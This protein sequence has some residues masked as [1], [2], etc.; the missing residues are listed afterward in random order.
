MKENIVESAIVPYNPSTSALINKEQ[1]N[2][3]APKGGVNKIGLAGYDPADFIVNNQI[4]S[5]KNKAVGEADVNNIPSNIVFSVDGIKT[6]NIMFYN[7]AYGVTLIEND[8]P[9]VETLIGILIPFVTKQVDGNFTQTEYFLTNRD[10]FV[11]DLT[12]EN[13][14]VTN[15]GDFRAGHPTVVDAITESE[16]GLKVSFTDGSSS[17]VNVASNVDLGPDLTAIDKYMLAG[18]VYSFPLT[19]FDISS[20]YATIEA[21]QYIGGTYIKLL[22][23]MFSFVITQTEVIITNNSG[24]AGDF[25]FL[26]IKSSGERGVKPTFVMISPLNF[27]DGKV[28]IKSMLS[29]DTHNIIIYKIENGKSFDITS[30]KFI[31]NNTVYVSYVPFNGVA[32]FQPYNPEK[33]DTYTKAVI[34]AKDAATLSSAKSY[35]D[36]LSVILA[37]KDLNNVDNAAFTQKGLMNDF[38]QDDMATVD[39]VKLSEKVLEGSIGMALRNLAEAVSVNKIQADLAVYTLRE[40][41]TSY[42]FM[43]NN[44]VEAFSIP[45]QVPYEGIK[46]IRSE[47]TGPVTFDL[48]A[49]RYIAVYQF[50]ANDQTYQQ[51]LPAKVDVLKGYEILIIVLNSTD[52]TNNKIVFSTNDGQ[53]ING[54]SNAFEVTGIGYRGSLILTDNAGWQSVLE[55]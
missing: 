28:K 36:D 19:R 55:Q 47:E 32:I 25:R 43:N 39:V 40:D 11:R 12:I 42:K 44:S 31:E 45:K 35:A 18:E 29:A 41:T 2:L 54:T 15:I 26:L 22:P 30:S 16:N 48:T 5:L 34:D 7:F 50:T 8:M 1:Y 3:F 20:G 53:Q 51:I 21:W 9:V 14:T 4:V 6:P 52:L 27:E 13:G 46:T 23:Q 17:N 37:D 38:L 49:Q 10:V 33:I 24:D